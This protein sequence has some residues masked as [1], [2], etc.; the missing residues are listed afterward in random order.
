MYHSMVL[1]TEQV[2]SGGTRTPF[3]SRCT[4]LSGPAGHQLYGRPLL[5][6]AGDREDSALSAAQERA[7][8]CHVQRHIPSQ[9]PGAGQLRPEPAEAGGRHSGRGANACN[10]AGV[11][12]AC[13][14][15]NTRWLHPG[16]RLLRCHDKGCTLQTKHA[17]CTHVLL[18]LCK[19]PFQAC[20][21]RKTSSGSSE[22]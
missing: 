16:N 5:V 4:D 21:S 2:T 8:E 22:K 19:M 1:C 14:Y 11:P 3:P 10:R 20:H 13:M 18:S 6:Q 12:P 9:H 15:L 7:A 17:I